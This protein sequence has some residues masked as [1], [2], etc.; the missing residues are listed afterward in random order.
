MIEVQIKGV[1]SVTKGLDN[2][3]KTASH[4]MGSSLE[5]AARE[6]ASVMKI[7]A[8]HTTGEL[9]SYIDY[10]VDRG[11][12]EA[13]IGP[14]DIRQTGRR[15]G[16]SVEKGLPPG[17]KVAPVV[18]MNRYGLALAQAMVGSKTIQARGVRANPFI[19]KTMSMAKN[20]FEN[21]A[22]KAVVNIVSKF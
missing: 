12:L 2:V 22:V 19:S 13:H 18:L 9:Q 7:Q 20:I 17:H 10:D 16:L 4:E 6:T 15:V 11:G 21:Y 8:P 3:S 14:S 5:S 1:D